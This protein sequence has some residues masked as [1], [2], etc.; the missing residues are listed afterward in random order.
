MRRRCV[1]RLS[2]MTH[3]TIAKL[4]HPLSS[5]WLERGDSEKF[6]ILRNEGSSSIC[7]SYNR[8]FT[9]FSMTNLFPNL[10]R[11]WGEPSASVRKSDR[12]S[13][14]LNIPRAP[15]FLNNG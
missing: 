11:R 15:V 9:T 14:Y 6:V 7:L 1:T 2:Q 12:F 8:C 4:G 13:V 10:R 3:P 5:A